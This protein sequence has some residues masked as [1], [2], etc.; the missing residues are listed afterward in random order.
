MDEYL[1]LMT[2]VS[3]IAFELSWEIITG[4]VIYLIGWKRGRRFVIR[5]HDEKY[6]PEQIHGGQDVP[7]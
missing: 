4:A 7:Q 2:D 6:H 1:H 5:K 3:H